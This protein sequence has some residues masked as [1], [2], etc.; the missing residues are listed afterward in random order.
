[1]ENQEDSKTVELHRDRITISDNRYLIFYTFT[2]IAATGPS[3]G[4]DSERPL[5]C[6]PAE[7]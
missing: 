2:D 3:K 7:T 1:M 4:D 6:E 5:P